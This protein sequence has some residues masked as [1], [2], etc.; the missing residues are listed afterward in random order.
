MDTDYRI[1]RHVEIKPAYSSETG[2]RT[3]WDEIAGCCGWITAVCGDYVTVQIKN[4]DEAEVY[5]QRI[6]LL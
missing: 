1:G 2:A 5:C 4:G 6:K 3:I